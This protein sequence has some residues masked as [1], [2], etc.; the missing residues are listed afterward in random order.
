MRCAAAHRMRARTAL[1]GKLGPE[2]AGL[3]GQGAQAGPPLEYLVDLPHQR[4]GPG[5]VG[6]REVHAD[7]RN[8]E[9]DGP[10]GIRVGHQRPQAQGAH[11]FPET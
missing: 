9:L 5:H 4:P 10:V 2:R 11:E 6:K 8:P 1:L 7:E 3:V